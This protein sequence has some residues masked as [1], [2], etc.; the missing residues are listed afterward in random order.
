MSESAPSA[1]PGLTVL[2]EYLAVA[3]HDALLTEV[4]RRPWLTDLR[5]RVQHYGYRYD[6]TA[7]KVDSAL[8]LGPLP[9]WAGALARRLTADGWFAEEPDQVIVNEYEPGQG[10]SKHVDCVPCFGDTIA[11]FSLGSTCVIQFAHAP[12]ERKVEQ[13]LPA[14]CLVV[15]QDDARYRWTH[16]IPARKSDTFEGREYPRGRRVSLTFRKVRLGAVEGG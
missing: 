4:D 12:T 7:K 15:M 10:I 13:L 14:R 1:V 3:D 8:Y 9:D 16:A 11:S 5:R 2:P 6:Y